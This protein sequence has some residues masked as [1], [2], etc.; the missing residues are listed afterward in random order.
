MQR[1]CR[2]GALG[3]QGRPCLFSVPWG[4]Q[5]GFP[6]SR[7][8]YEAERKLLAAPFQNGSCSRGSEWEIYDWHCSSCNVQT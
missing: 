5:T 7:L 4:E 1:G 2:K 8:D 3:F 6:W